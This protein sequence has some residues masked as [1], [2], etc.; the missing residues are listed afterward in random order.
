M[1]ISVIINFVKGGS[2]MSQSKNDKAGTTKSSRIHS[3]ASEPGTHR[4]NGQGSN[5]STAKKR[6]SAK[7]RKTKQKGPFSFV[8]KVIFILFV[9]I[10]FAICGALIG[11]YVGIIKN[12][13]D[14]G[15]ISVEPNVYTSIIYDK[16]GNEIDRLHGDE[17]REYANITQIPKYMQDAIIA[18]EDSRFYSHNGVDPRGIA[19]AAF[20]TLTGKR[21]EGGSTI[22]QQL[23][24]NNVTKVTHNTITTKLQEQ[25]LAAKYEKELTEQLGS[26]EAAKKYILELYLNTIG[27]GHG[28]NG[29]QAASLGYFNKDASELNLAECASLAGVTNN[30]VQYS[31][32][33]QPEQNKTRQTIILK[34]MLEQE[35][36]TQAEYDTALAEDIYSKISQ[37]SSSD[38]ITANDN[39]TTN[40]HSYFV[41]S[42]FNQISR[43]LQDKYNISATQ[44]NY[45][46]YNGGLQITATIDTEMQKIVDEAYLDSSL[47][48]NVNYG[49]DVNYLVSVEDSVTGQQEHSEYK[50]F[51]KTRESA[52]QW[53]ADKKASIEAGLS[54]T[55]S[56]IAD[57]ANYTV[58]P[59]SAMIIIDY[60]TGEV[61]A[62]AGGRGEKL[63]NRA[64]NRAVDSARQPGSVFKILAAYAAGIDQGTLTASTLIRDEP[65]TIGKYSPSNWWGK[66]Y[67]GDCTVRVGIRDSMNILAVKA[68]VETGID[69]CYDYL[70]NFGFT[71]LEDDNHAATALGGLTNGVTQME[72]AAAYGAIANGGEY[73]RPMLYSMVLDHNGNVLL[74]NNSEPRT[75]LQ[76]SAAYV[77]TDMMRD[78]VKSGTGTKAKFINSKMP[79]VGKTG[80]TTDSKDLT[81]VGYTPYY[82]ASVWLGYD[83]YDDTVKN[84]SKI[85]QSSHLVLW[86]TVMEKIHEGLEVK[87]FTKPDNVVSASV[88]KRTGK[89]ASKY[90]ESYT[91]VFVSGTQPTSYCAGHRSETNEDEK[92]TEETTELSTTDNSDTSNDNNSENTQPTTNGTSGT[93]SPTEP[94]T[95]APPVSETPAETPAEPSEVIVEPT[96]SALPE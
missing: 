46:L 69:I 58:Q 30:P 26:K 43:D 67:R 59:Q 90:C 29:V 39:P 63:V 14:L 31:P 80:T 49:I 17:N 11:A 35:Y 52:E 51:A 34:Y 2:L 85:D 37:S 68:M 22:T 24:K 16:D 64:F 18:I 48:P 70:L 56:I 76:S 21:L 38:E 61:K 47:F 6:R 89:L 77:L 28:Y 73:R 44:A 1:Y 15:M 36:I 20:S 8:L 78:V 13:P 23:I 87:D 66:S 62:L 27:L 92:N 9:I 84:M 25:Y 72:V 54:S 93:D 94:A 33:T 53:V 71:T 95:T 7:K 41:D 5:R 96:V 55:Q 81:F 3:S 42:L 83:R 40:I 75:V 57:K 10:A 19:R 12:A 86:R 82:V 79:V 60:R 74:E 32:R 45:I 88:C 4:S 91:E 65:Y 50:Q